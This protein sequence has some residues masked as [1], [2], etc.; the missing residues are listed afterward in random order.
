MEKERNGFILV[1]S[2]VAE[3]SLDFDADIIITELCPMDLL[4]QRM[5]REHRHKIHDKIRPKKL[6]KPRC[7]IIRDDGQSY[8]KAS[9]SVYDESILM[10]TQAILPKQIDI[11]NDIPKL[12]QTVYADGN[13]WSHIE[14]YVE[15]EKKH[16]K[17]MEEQEQKA[18]VYL[19]SKPPKHEKTSRREKKLDS[20]LK[21]STQVN[22]KQAEASVRDV[23]PSLEVLVLQRVNGKVRFLPWED[24]GEIL[25]GGQ[26]PQADVCKKIASQRLRLPSSLCRRDKL[27]SVIAELE[28]RFER[29]FFVWKQSPWING[30]LLLV[31]DEDLSDVLC[32]IKLSYSRQDGL[33]DMEEKNHE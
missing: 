27:G 10:K 20:F 13:D 30:E 4:L 16:K 1:A 21:N 23:K 7:I 14:G 3:Q 17:K 25:D 6:S 12:V 31:L 29:D 9:K 32:G 2:Q 8:D 26:L 18:S 22:D 19:L 28:Q 11:P 24:K 5:G 15:A 33:T